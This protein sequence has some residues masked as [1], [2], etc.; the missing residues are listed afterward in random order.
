VPTKTKVT[1]TANKEAELSRKTA[2]SSHTALSLPD[3][4]EPGFQSTAGNLAVQRLFQSG[5]IQAKL[6][7]SQPGDPYE[8]E[9]E[10]VAEQ[11]M[12][13]PGSGIQATP[14]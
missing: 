3:V 1:E 6:T 5:A 8:R 10:N 14:G 13:M 9:A 2:S 7:L 12:R 4:A 11:V